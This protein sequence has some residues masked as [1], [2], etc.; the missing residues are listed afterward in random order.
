[1]SSFDIEEIKNLNEQIQEYNSKLLRATTEKERDTWAE[2]IKLAREEK[3]AL[4]K[5]FPQAGK[6]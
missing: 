1:M 4:V 5:A 3:I 6:D 2:Q